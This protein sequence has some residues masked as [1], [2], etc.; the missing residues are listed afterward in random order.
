M[1]ELVDSDNLRVLLGAWSSLQGALDRILQEENETGVHGQGLADRMQQFRTGLLKSFG[2]RAD[3]REFRARRDEESSPTLDRSAVDLLMALAGMCAQPESEV[4][5]A[6]SLHS[7][8]RGVRQQLRARLEQVNFFTE[9]AIEDYE[10]QRKRPQAE[11]V[12]QIEQGAQRL[13]LLFVKWIAPIARGLHAHQVAIDERAA[14]AASAAARRANETSVKLEELGSRL[15]E[16]HDRLVDGKLVSTLLT[17]GG[18]HLAASSWNRTSGFVVLLLAAA[19]TVRAEDLYRLLGTET[20]EDW[21][22]RLGIVLLIYG[23]GGWLLRQSTY[24]RRAA[25]AL[26]LRA[27]ALETARIY[28][29]DD[30][31]DESRR[32]R[33]SELAFDLA[34]SEPS[35]FKSGE[36]KTSEVTMH[37]A[38][39]GNKG[40]TGSSS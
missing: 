34:L 13:A 37:P 15:Q 36:P 26:R 22:I 6:R 4:I 30:A 14:A 11:I 23:I 39:F 5:L 7:P 31:I 24:H 19:V 18:E 32:I 17:L 29:K 33:I 40:P 28:L 9:Q 2:S 8:D 1:S 35:A 3:P 10:Y 21:R 27:A 16:S 12:S 38:M 25:D 20:P